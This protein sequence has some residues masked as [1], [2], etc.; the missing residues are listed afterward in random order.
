MRWLIALFVCPHEHVTWPQRRSQACLD[1]GA[2]R[3][4][5]LGGRVGKWGKHQP[6]Q[7]DARELVERRC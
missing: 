5:V 2:T 6:L 3:H 1:C 7:Q 4:Y